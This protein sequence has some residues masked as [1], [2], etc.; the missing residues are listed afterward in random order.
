MADSGH[1]YALGPTRPDGSIAPVSGPPSSVGIDNPGSVSVAREGFLAWRP[2]RV[3]SVESGA[4]GYSRNQPFAGRGHPQAASAD[5]AGWM[6]RDLRRQKHTQGYCVEE[7][8]RSA[9]RRPGSQRLSSKAARTFMAATP[10]STNS[11]RCRLRSSIRRSGNILEK[12]QRLVHEKAIYAPVWEL[13]LLNGVG[14]PVGGA[15]F[16]EI[17][18]GFAYTAPFEDIA[19]RT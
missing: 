15:S 11:N 3:L 1:Q 19:I 4:L 5:R 10:R 18:G 9:M 7:G 17:P 8:A 13:A 16:G 6:C 12:I 2:R 14:P